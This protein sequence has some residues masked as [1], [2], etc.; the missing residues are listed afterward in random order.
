[1]E[2]ILCAALVDNRVLYAPLDKSSEEFGRDHLGETLAGN[3]STTK[4]DIKEH[5][6][7][8]AVLRYCVNNM[9]KAD[10]SEM[11]VIHNNKDQ[12]RAEE[13]LLVCL[14]YS[15]GFTKTFIDRDGKERTIP[16]TT[17]MSTTEERVTVFRDAA[18]QMLSLWMGMS[19]RDLIQAS[20]DAR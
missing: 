19:Y 2:I 8:R 18:Y 15:C 6:K 14:K 9:R 3:V 7:F 4:R 16:D 17:S 13:H 12:D 11:Y 1:M 20:L 10:G 5:D